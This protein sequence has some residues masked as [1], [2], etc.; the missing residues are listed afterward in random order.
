[1]SEADLPLVLKLNNQF[2]DEVG[3]ITSSKLKWLFKHS[4]QAIVALDGKKICAF[5]LTFPEKSQYNSKNYLLFSTMT[6]YVYLDRIVVDSSYQGQ[7]IGRQ[8]YKQVM[9][10]C[11]ASRLCLEVNVVPKN[12]PSLKFHQKMGFKKHTRV[13]HAPDYVVQTMYKQLKP[14]KA[15][16]IEMRDMTEAD[17]P[18]VLKMNNAFKAE[19]STQTLKSLTAMYKYS[20]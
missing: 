12:E 15:P 16:K 10:T 13:E 7:G 19:M 17:L 4:H 9:D 5:V 2:V 6:D 11:G 14:Y 3:E 20:A 18:T 8:L 1:M